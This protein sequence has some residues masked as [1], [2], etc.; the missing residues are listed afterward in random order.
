[1]CIS[2]LISQKILRGISEAYFGV[3]RFIF[4][5]YNSL[6]SNSL[7]IV[8]IG[9]KIVGQK[10]NKEMQSY[11]ENFLFSKYISFMIYS[12]IYGCPCVAKFKK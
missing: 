12:P 5:N 11:I 10:N 7:C 2:L 4:L 6:L 3:N 1:M 9:T 8:D